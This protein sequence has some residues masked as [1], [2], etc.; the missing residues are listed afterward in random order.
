MQVLEP[1]PALLSEGSA[2]EARA[3]GGSRAAMLTGFPL[4]PPLARPFG[5]RCLPDS[6]G[7]GA[8]RVDSLKI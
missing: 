4:E 6:G 2:G 3:G 7:R 5:P 8:L 1:F